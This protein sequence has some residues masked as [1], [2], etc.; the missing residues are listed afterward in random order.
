MNVVERALASI[1]PYAKNPRKNEPAVDAVAAS[2]QAFGFRV[3]IVIDGDGEIIA[4]HT[5]FLA[6]QKLGLETVPCVLADDL[7]PQKVRAFRLADNKTAELALWNDVLLAAELAAV[8]DIDMAAFGFD[9]SEFEAL[10]LDGE[11]PQSRGRGSGKPCTCPKC[12]FQF[13]L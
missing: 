8:A 1:H 11:E 10:D 5:R 9:V 13:L 2:I 7:P 4:G 12:G 3:P 6:A